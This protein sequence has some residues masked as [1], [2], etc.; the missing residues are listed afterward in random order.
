MNFVKYGDKED[1]EVQYVE[2][3]FDDMERP[4]FG[5][6]VKLTLREN[7]PCDFE[8]PALAHAYL[9]LI[10]KLRQII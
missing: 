7:E 6:N 10:M 4:R 3:C 5:W 2:D 1:T 9:L 8:N